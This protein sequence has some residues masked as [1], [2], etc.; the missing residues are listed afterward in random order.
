MRIVIVDLHCNG[1]LLRNFEYIIDR[2][3]P[4]MKHAF[5]LKEALKEGYEIINYI[6]GTNSGLWI[7]KNSLLLNRM[8]A[9]Y[10]L[11]K[12]GCRHKIC[13]TTDKKEIRQDDIVIFYS[14]TD[15]KFDLDAVPGRKFCN[16]NHFFSMCSC[17]KRWLP[18]FL[19]E[20]SFE[21]Y[22]CEA[23]VCNDSLLFRKYLPVKQKKM[24]LMPY[25]AEKRFQKK[26]PFAQR[27]NKALALGS[28]SIRLDLLVDVY[29]TDQLHPMRSEILARSREN[30]GQIECMIEKIVHPQD[31]FRTMESDG[32]VIKFVKRFCNHFYRNA[33]SPFQ[34]N[35]KNAGYYN[36]DMVQLLNE[37]KM[38]IFPEEVTGIPALGFVEGMSCGC[39]YIGI[40][41]SM[42]AKIGMQ[43]GIHYIGYNGTYDDLVKKIRYYQV[44]EKEAEKIAEKGY[45][46]VKENLASGKVFSR[47]ME[48]LQ[49]TE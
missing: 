6:T 12:N 23:D 48:Q 27:K 42:Y 8:E 25:V 2:R 20:E 9:A 17:G 31:L 32:R 33:N 26:R 7:G 21:G 24:I 44:H 19:K 10:V 1:F 4:V 40:E 35:G 15:D 22:I 30:T 37:Y 3:R 36:K 46:F 13:N 41:S 47:V 45:R 29:G 14:H 39:A 18:D 16:V 43:S 38:F 49:K 11:W 34:K 5:F 28:C